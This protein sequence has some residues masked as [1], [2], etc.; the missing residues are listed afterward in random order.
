MRDLDC[1]IKIL[2]PREQ[3][4]AVDKAKREGYARILSLEDLLERDAK[5]RA[6]PS[7]PPWD[8]YSN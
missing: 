4:P 7:M 1:L 6:S 5:V 8:P 3:T 2:D